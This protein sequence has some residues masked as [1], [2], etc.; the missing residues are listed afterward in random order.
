VAQLADEERAGL[1]RGLLDQAASYP[2]A[3]LRAIEDWL[4]G[5]P[6]AL[7]SWR[8]F[9]ASLALIEGR[10]KPSVAQKVL[11]WIEAGGAFEARLAGV[12]C[13]GELRTRIGALLRQWRSSDRL[14]FPA[15]EAAERVGL[16][17]EAAS[18][19]AARQRA[20]EKLFSQVGKAVETDVPLMTRATWGRLKTELE[21]MERELRTTV[22]AAIQKARELGDLRE[23]AEYEAA[24]HKQAVL[25]KQ[26]A[27]LQLRLAHARFIEDA[28]YQDGVVGPGMEVVLESERDM[29][30]YWILGEGEHHHGDHVISHRAPVARSLLGKSIGD[31]VEL[32]EGEARQRF[33][34]VSVERRL[35]PSAAEAE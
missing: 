12:A 19:R 15:L 35:P 1:Y 2:Q 16:T 7:E 21:R 13:P 6:P 3:A 11:A 26:V 22:P 23:N 5:G 8:A 10:P 25:Q 31:E 17:A 24:K 32:G 33:R 14:L 30:S 28:E 20:T 27:A 18:V 9:A 4:D 29:V 34:V